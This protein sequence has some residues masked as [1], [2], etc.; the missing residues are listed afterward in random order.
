M[1]SD[2]DEIIISELDRL[3]RFVSNRV[4]DEY[5]AEDIVQDIVLAAY[6]SYERLRDK[7]RTLP[8]LWGIAR[9]MVMRS[10]RPS[11]ET[12]TDE[13][14][15]I[16]AA[17]VSHETPESEFFKKDDITKIRRAVSYLAKNY[18]DVCIM[19]Y[20]EE[21]DYGTIAK[22]LGIPLSSVKWRLS[23]TKNQLK[24][25]LTKM[26][27]MENGYR[28]ARGL[29][30]QMG[31]WVG[32][33]N[34][35]EGCYDNADKALDGLLP[36]NICISAYESAKTVTEISS[37]LG[38]A[39][40][41]VEESLDRLVKTQSVKKIGNRYRTMFPIW[42]KAAMEDIYDGNYNFAKAE[43]DGILD[44][45]YSLS[46][47]IKD[48]GFYGSDREIDKLILFLAG[49]VCNGT[50]NN[51]F[52]K[53][54]LPFTGND[55]AWYIIAHTDDGA[56][57]PHDIYGIN[58]N[59]SMFGLVEYYFAQKYTE[60]KR[61]NR[62]EEQKVFYS[63]YK[64]E[65]V[66]DEYSLSKVL[67]SGKVVKDGDGYR[68]TVPVLSTTNGEWQKLKEVLVPVFAKTNEIQQKIYDRSC[69]TVLKYLPKHLSEGLEFFGSY[70]ALGVLEVALGEAILARGVEITPDMATWFCVE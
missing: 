4:R 19:Y 55:K 18:R 24:E 49:F 31:G 10:Y 21:K 61:F 34:S 30:L 42:N 2:L 32:K 59:G 52:R 41:Y 23:E 9:N 11:A 63:I 40:D 8:W 20:L 50:E 66:T 68:I 43:A 64:G 13:I 15:I 70:C 35:E 7:K 54:L 5:K 17:G 51:E 58:T 26:D 60:D 62:T 28:K 57:E 3:Y 37:D 33:W 12:P 38:V 69:K 27:Y 56:Y 48:I 25:E 1:N 14:T 65:K 53:D 16:T 67:E 39:A 29:H 45:L 36:K 44:L 6:G 22:E 47:K 46:D